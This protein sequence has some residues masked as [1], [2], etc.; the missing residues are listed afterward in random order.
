MDLQNT[1]ISVLNQ[2]KSV[3]EQVSRDDYSRTISSHEASIGEHTRHTI[4]F[5]QCLLEGFVSGTVN[6]DK[7]KRNIEIQVSSGNAISTINNIIDNINSVNDD[8]GLTLEISYDLSDESTHRI[9]SSYK[10]ELAYNIE[11]AIHHMAIIK[12]MIV[13]N[14]SYIVIPEN[15]GIAISTVKYRNRTLN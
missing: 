2:L 1:A 8:A 7:R 9:K 10:R 15:F 4:E 5:Y 13:E 14:F 11:H 3:V 12:S 6:Y